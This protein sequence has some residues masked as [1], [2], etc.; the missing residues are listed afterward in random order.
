MGGPGR[1]VPVPFTA[2]LVRPPCGVPP[3]L[4]S[5]DSESDNGLKPKNGAMFCEFALGQPPSAFQL[6]AQGGL[7][8]V[9]GNPAS[10]QL[11]GYLSR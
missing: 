1:V 4:Q 3:C 5:G 8:V 11:P 9:Q 7:L 6:G 10:W 2:M